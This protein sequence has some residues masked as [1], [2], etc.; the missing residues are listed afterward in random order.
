MLAGASPLNMLV[1]C[2]THQC[3]VPVTKTHDSP[4]REYSDGFPCTWEA[5]DE[6]LIQTA[7][8]SRNV[9]GRETFQHYHICRGEHPFSYSARTGCKAVFDGLFH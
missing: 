7:Q 5:M 3:L 8:Y 1:L 4:F 9:G 2:Y 6:G